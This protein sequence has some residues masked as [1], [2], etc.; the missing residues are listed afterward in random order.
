MPGGIIAISGPCSPTPVISPGWTVPPP[1]L[2]NILPFPPPNGSGDLGVTVDFWFAVAD[3]T[4]ALK[5]S[6][7]VAVPNDLPYTGAV[8]GTIGW[9]RLVVV[10]GAVSGVA[11]KGVFVIG[12]ETPGV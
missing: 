12:G 11:A 8:A 6:I 7:L 1:A 4:K 9:A 5:S 2:P 3:A 10:T